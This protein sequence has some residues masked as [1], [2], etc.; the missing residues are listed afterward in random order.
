[1][2]L[3]RLLGSI[4]IDNDTA[5]QKIDETDNKGKGLAG[6]LANTIGTAAKWGAGIV[7]GA[8]AAVGGMVALANR[9]A[10]AADAIDKLSERTGINRE[11]LQR[12]KYAADQSGADVEKLEVGIKTLSN[13]MDGAS[14]GNKAAA[15]AFDRLG[16]S[17]RNADG[18]ARSTEAVFQDVMNALADMDKGAARNAV[19][20]D[21]LG[22]SYTEMLPLLNAGSKGMKDLMARADELGIVMSEDAV[23]ANVKFGD[24]M[25]DLKAA[26]GGVFARVSNEALPILQSFIDWILANMPQIQTVV[27]GVFGVVSGVLSAVGS[28]I[29]TFVLP[30]LSAIWSFIQPYF[31]Q[32]EQ[33]FRAAFGI[34][35]DILGGIARA[36]VDLTRWFTQHWEIMQPILWGIAAGA[37]TFGIYQLAINAAAIATAAWSAITATATAVGAAFG[38]VVAFITSPIGIVI[39]AVALLVA[40]I[41]VLIKHWDDVKAAMQRAWDKVVDFIQPVIDV[42]QGVIDKVKLAI[43]WFGR[44]FGAQQRAANADIGV[45]VTPNEMGPNA[46]KMAKG[47]TV[48]EPGMALVGEN[49]PELRFLP[50]GAKI[51]PLDRLSAAGSTPMAESVFGRGAFEGAVITDDY[52]VDRLMDRVMERL[53]QKGVRLA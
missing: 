15:S 31:P 6:T 36:V 9:T 18:S 23:M 17:L 29:T 43:D 4:F 44:L 48:R 46:P 37:A 22:K 19:G 7:A 2:E 39:A 24:T 47:G 53:A 11:D 1:M 14:T 27:S 45:S 42:V 50:A 5:N 21:L 33:L 30:A 28:V 52:G 8:S 12:W 10:E 20:A 3:F 38:A 40:G 49:G 32:I 13:A 25:D 34:M 41:V 16:I 51:I 35:G 26:I